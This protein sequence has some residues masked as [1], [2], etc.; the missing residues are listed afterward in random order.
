M[1]NAAGIESIAKAMS[2]KT[3]AV[4]L[5]LVGVKLLIE[6]AVHVSPEASLGFVGLAFAIGIVL[7]L[8]ADR[9]D[10]RLGQVEDEPEHGVQAE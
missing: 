4:V 3:I 10:R 8:W 6:D 2:A 1:A 9:R 7:S 5:G